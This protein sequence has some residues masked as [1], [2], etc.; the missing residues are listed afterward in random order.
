MPLIPFPA[1]PFYPGVPALVRGANVPV[2]IQ[3]A[4]GDIQ[5]VLASAMQQTQQWGIFDQNGNQ[6]GLLD[7]EGN[8]L[9]KSI[10][11]SI[12]GNIRPV[13]STNAVE[14]T[15]DTKI[16]DFPIENGG[17][18]SYNKVI[19]PV[20]PVVT[21]ALQGTISERAAFIGLIEAA[22]NSTDL[23]NVVTP[24]VVYVNYCLERTNQVRRADR[25]AS[26]M[27]IEISLKE[28]RQVSAA[29]SNVQTPINAPQN[30]AATPA[31][32]SGLV[33]SQAPNE[34]VLKSIYNLFPSL[35]GAK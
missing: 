1:V 14:I 10:I 5:T 12:S 17:F 11:A 28:I 13:L 9:F 26:L 35:S 33:Q 4:L 30:P 8:G 25:G 6:L 31:S 24:E 16:S 18:A 19:L 3:V 32:N 21:L 7:N 22:C 29:F 27:F 15:K 2:G 23:Y 20:E 34:S